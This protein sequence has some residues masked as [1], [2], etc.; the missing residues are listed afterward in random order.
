MNKGDETMSKIEIL[1]QAK[2]FGQARNSEGFA[3]FAEQHRFVVKN[4]KS[5]KNDG[6]VEVIEML[7]AYGEGLRSVM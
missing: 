1:N 4:A 5:K 6:K 3:E 2:A 7:R